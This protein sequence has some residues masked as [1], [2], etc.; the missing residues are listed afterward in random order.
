MKNIS[1]YKQVIIGIDH[2]YG[3]IKTAHEVFRCG[4]DKLTG[5][6]IASENVLR[7]RGGTYV[8]GESHL[9]YRGEKTTDNSF[10]LLTLAAIAEELKHKGGFTDA[11]V[12]LA[13]GLPLARVSGQ[14]DAFREYLMQDAEPEFDYKGKHYHLH[15][16]K[17]LIFPQ[18]FAETLTIGK[19]PGD[20]MI[21]DI[22]NGTMN[23]AKVVDG[24]P[25]E[26]SLVTLDYG[27]SFCV[28]DIQK[29]LSRKLGRDVDEMKIE[30]RL[31]NGCKGESNEIS[32]VTAEVAEAYASDIVNRLPVY[33]YDE[34]DT[35]LHI[36]G[37][38]GCLL[39]NYSNLRE[40]GNVTFYDDICANAKGYEIFAQKKMESGGKG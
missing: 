24:R 10:Y 30:R 12:I 17:V 27:V 40:Q 5:D 29:T 2:G 1:E 35:R 8:I 16:D 23:V 15:I 26:S 11:N 19:L 6:A 3:N 32:A 36:F 4:V 22:G 33:G 9:M 37:G 18:G 14:K 21:L 25:I 31:M 13:V 20:N 7:Y 38:G 39:R 34:I 28:R